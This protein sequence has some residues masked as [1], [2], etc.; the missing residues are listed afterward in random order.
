MSF[1]MKILIF[2]ALII[3]AG[4]FFNQSNTSQ[5]LPHDCQSHILGSKKG[6]Q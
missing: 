4:L 1:H 3:L 5:R 2:T 6:S